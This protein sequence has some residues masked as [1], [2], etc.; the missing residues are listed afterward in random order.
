MTSMRPQIGSSRRIRRLIVSVSV[1]GAVLTNHSTAAVP[2]HLPSGQQVLTFVADTIDWYR[3]IPGAQ[4]I[5]TE[6]AD[7]L[8]LESNRSITTEIV[9]LSFEFGKAVAAIDPAEN[10][11]DP[12]TAGPPAPKS[13][14]QY[15]VGAQTMLDAKTQEALSQLRSL[16]AAQPTAHR[17]DRERLGAQIAE[18]QRR[19]QLLGVM[20]ANYNTLLGFV[21]N[22]S[23]DPVPDTSLA[24]LVENLERTVPDVPVTARPVQ[25]PVILADPSRVPAGIMGRISQVSDVA[26][27]K[28][29]I[30]ELIER[31]DALSKSLQ[32]IRSPLRESFRKEFAAFSLEATSLDVLQQQGSRLSDL[33]ADAKTI[34]PAMAAL[35]KQQTLLNLYR[36]HLTGWRSEIHAESAVAW[37]SLLSR[38]GILVAAI[39]LLLAVGAMARRLTYRHV[40]D[41]D[42]RQIVLI[43]ERVL[44]W[45]TIAALVLFAFALDLTSLATFLGLLSAGLAVALHDVFLAVGGYLLIVRRFHVRVGDRVQVSSVTGEVTNL[46]LLQFQLSE[47]D[48]ATG[49]RTGREAFFSNSYVFVSP[50]TPLFRQ[51]SGAA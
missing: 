40:R 35:I 50:A 16:T 36:T 46:G 6:P 9:R 25:A 20:T 39:A 29:A 32:N 8:F 37:K 19:I 11:S 21:R 42:T 7:L 24:A 14:L 3:H 23:A 1:A 13:E 27:K 17:A 43:G 12:P 4:Q 26:R 41:F 22:A 5:G 34:S 15:L 2:N 30:D 49:E 31:T 10:P 28:R 38:I 45:L 44:L 48:P 47:I 18:I 33:V 51:A